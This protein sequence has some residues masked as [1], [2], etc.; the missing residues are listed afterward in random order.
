MS[1]I[2]LVGINV[3]AWGAIHI[4]VAA[5]GTRLPLR[6]FRPEALWFRT[7]TWEHR[8]RLYQKLFRIR[9]WKDRVPDGASWLKGGFPKA[10]LLRRDP[11]YLS[12][13]AQETCRGEAVHTVVILCA[14]LFF[15]WNPPWAGGLMIL[16]AL[17]ANLPCIL[18]QRYNRARLDARTLH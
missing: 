18:I 11:A 15:F 14:P 1:I 7:R 8:G 10:R 12:R 3:L 16:Y 5:C 13:F 17:A 6:W 9:H 4:G 2:E